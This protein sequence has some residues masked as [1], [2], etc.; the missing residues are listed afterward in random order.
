MVDFGMQCISEQ[1]TCVYG[2]LFGSYAYPTCTVSGGSVQSCTLDGVTVAHGAIRKFYSQRTAENASV[3]AVASIDR[4]CQNGTLSGSNMYQYSSC[5][6]Q[7]NTCTPDAPQTQTLA[8]PAGQTG[9]IVQTRTSSCPGPT[10]SGWTTTSNTCTSVPPPLSCTFN[11]QTV[12]HGASVTAYQASSVPAGNQCISEQR[13]CNNGTLTGSYINSSCTVAGG[14]TASGVGKCIY[15][16]TTY[17]NGDTITVHA[18]ADWAAANWGSA[19]FPTLTCNNGW[20]LTTGAYKDACDTA[21]YFSASTLSDLGCNWNTANGSAACTP[22]STV[23]AQPSSGPAPLTV[24]ITLRAMAGPFSP[25]YNFGDMT[26]APG[27]M[28]SPSFSYWSADYDYT[29]CTKHTYTSPGTFI[30]H[31]VDY[32]GGAYGGPFT[33]TVTGP[34]SDAQ[35][36]SNLASALA[37]LESALSAIQKLLG[38]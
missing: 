3:C 20:T 38:M 12:A 23:G 25:G 21:I 5:S 27:L 35:K 8:C 15:K 2:T 9:T 28:S 22:A 34:V 1:R 29:Y 17:A 30:N 19:F 18:D 33:V 11:G 7:G 10:W 6:V 13:T 16:G 36:N 24:T 31:S 26:G 32:I 37:A 4:I 14:G